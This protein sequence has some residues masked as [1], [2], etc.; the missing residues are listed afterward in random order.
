MFW[1]IHN[2]DVHRWA[3]SY[4]KVG[5][6]GVGRYWLFFSPIRDKRVVRVMVGLGSCLLLPKCL[7]GGFQLSV[8]PQIIR[9]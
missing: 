2:E 5:G 8:L 6:I 9:V 1:Q 7:T 4:E 3:E